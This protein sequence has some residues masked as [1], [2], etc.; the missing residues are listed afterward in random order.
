MSATLKL[1]QN[2]I[3]LTLASVG[4]KVIAFVYFTIIARF[5]GLED[6]GAYF[7]SLAI[8][9]MLAVLDDLGV[10]SVVIRDV[11]KRNEE[12]VLWCQTVLGI[13]ILTIP[14]TILLA[15]LVPIWL[16]YTGDIVWL[17]RI[18]IG[19]MIADTLSL[20]FYGILRGLQALSYESLG[21]FLGQSITT[22]IG[23]VLIWSG[24]ATLP[25]LIVALVFGSSW[26]LF[27]SAFQVVRRLGWVA[28]KPTWS[29]GLKPLKL[30]WAFFLA[31]LFVKMYSYIDSVILSMYY[32]QDAVGTYAVAYK[33]T[34]AFQFLPLA[35]VAALYPSMSAHSTDRAELKRI[36]LKSLWYMALLSMPIVFGLWSL[37][38]EVIGAFYGMQYAGSVLPLQVLIFVL[39]FIFLDYPLGSLLNATNRQNIKTAIMG[40]TMV[41]NLVFNLI[42]I[43]KFGV[44]GACLSAL[45]CFSFMFLAGWLAVHKVVGLLP[46]E[47]WR[48]I[49]SLFISAALMALVVLLVKP[50]L[51]FVLAIPV[52][53]VVYLAS[54]TLFG[55]LRTEHW[56]GFIGLLRPKKVYESE[57]IV[58]NG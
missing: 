27:F 56:R 10:T 40:V 49:G 48:E 54:A 13:K 16:G 18:A 12:A 25:M 45:A 46:R 58:A 15:W 34:Y 41:I 6:T 53:A 29:M 20:S 52:G 23:V 22:V 39:L 44:V 2:A 19:I 14:L 31:A 50:Y 7:L 26:N 17:V 21:I 43:P 57:N 9:T 11:A 3:Y 38:P 32:G 47:L 5:A 35:F 55:A 1:A 8:V 51:H 42:L 30:A 4:Q 33:L 36:L 37:A 28:L 24:Q